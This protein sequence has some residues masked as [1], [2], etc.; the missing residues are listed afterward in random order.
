MGQVGVGEGE[1]KNVKRD[2]FWS[3]DITGGLK[4]L[5]KAWLEA[6]RGVQKRVHA[7]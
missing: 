1:K 7:I 6:W 5:R 4:M 3:P 2:T